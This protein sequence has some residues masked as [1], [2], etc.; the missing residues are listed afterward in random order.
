MILIGLGANLPLNEAMGP[1]E[2]LEAALT[3]LEKRGVEI[4]AR[5][6]WYESQPV[7]DDG[8]PWYINGVVSVKT[9]H[10]PHALLSTLLDV[11]KSFGRVREVRWASRTVDLD[12]LDYDG[13]VKTDDDT[14]T[15]PHPR[16]HER[17][18]V[19][20]PLCDI[21]P[22]WCHPTLNLSAKDILAAL[23]HEPIVRKMAL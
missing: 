3:A 5:S 17:R 12:I 10:E 19:V 14:L 23:P 4:L 16:M 22:D 1:T 2:T 8:Q 15:L 21:A 7:P 11:E 13:L 20:E 9:D 18:F 6:P